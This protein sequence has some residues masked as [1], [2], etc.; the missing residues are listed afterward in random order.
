MIN[1]EIK[2]FKAAQGEVGLS[3]FTL[4]PLSEVI[5]EERKHYFPYF[6]QLVAPNL[7]CINTQCFHD[8]Y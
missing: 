3:L 8:T 4:L 2:C 7:T 6:W 1:Y 5:F